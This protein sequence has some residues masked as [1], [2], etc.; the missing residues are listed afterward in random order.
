M[1]SIS[2]VKRIWKA[3]ATVGKSFGTWFSPII[4]GFLLIILRLFVGIC[5]MLD[6]LFFRNIREHSIKNPIVIVGNPRSGT[7]FLHRY[8]VNSNIGTGTQ[9]WQMIY[10]SVVLQ[11]FIRPFLPIL[12]KISP[13][14]HHST[15][16]HKTSLSSVETD[17]ASMLFRFFDGFFLY[18]FILAW[19]EQDLFHWFEP[20]KRDMS[21]R[22]FNWFESLWIRVLHSS[23]NKRIIG[24]LFSLS[25]NLPS[26]QNRYPDARVLYMIR[27]PLNV[28]PSGL[29][30]V[31][32]VLDKRFGFW[33]LPKEKRTLYIGRMYRALVQ[34]L[35]RFHSD[36]VNDRIDKT[37]VM[38]IRYDRMMSDFD[39]LMEDI[40]SFV[41]YTPTEELVKEI[42]NT[43]LEQRNYK[44]K[45]TYDLNK[46]GLNESQI[47]EDC[48][49]VY[50]T[51][52][53]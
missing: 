49:K 30:L 48:S 3:Y 4:T 20:E 43:A 14:R 11:K 46:F 40:L 5:M 6:K 39:E 21:K 33:S 17:D 52:L 50:E 8:L 38:I 53:S 28:L 19:A 37:K 10:P 9:L 16:A 29:S 25:A 24:K 12:E 41:D 51:F 47:K 2:I 35:L 32:G 36:W 27:D 44:S 23:E 22:D 42:Q 1:L 13:T 7:T 26:F 45:H 31:T 34:L 15:A 18:G